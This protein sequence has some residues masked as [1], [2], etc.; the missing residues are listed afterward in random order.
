MKR[1]IIAVLAAA[2][3]AVTFG[4]G[5]SPAA[6][7]EPD[8]AAY[9][10]IGDSVASGNGLLPYYDPGCLRSDKAYP[11]VLAAALG[12]QVVSAACSGA[13]TSVVAAQAAGLAAT[14][15]LGGDTESGDD[16]RGR[17]RPAVDPGAG[18]AAAIWAS[19]RPLPGRAR[20]R[21]AG[22]RRWGPRA[23]SPRRSAS[24][25]PTRPSAL[26]VVTGYPELFG[27]FS[28]T[29][30]VGAAGP[31]TPM[32]F[33]QPQAG[34]LERR[35]RRPQLR[36][37][38]RHRAVPAGVR[39]SQR[40]PS[41][42]LRRVHRR[43]GG[44]RRSRAVRQRRALD[45]R[46]R[47]RQDDAGPR[48]PPERRRPAGVRGDH[49]GDDCS[50][51]PRVPPSGGGAASAHSVHN[52][53]QAGSRHPA[54]QTHGM[55]LT[56][57]EHVP[58]GA[59]ADAVYLGFVEWAAGPGSH[60][61]S[62]PGRGDHRD[63]VGV[64]RDPV[65]ADRHRQVPRRRRRACRVPRPRRANV[66]HRADQGAREREVL[67]PGRH[68]RRRQRRHGHG[69]LVGEPGCADHLLHRRD[70]GEHRPAKRSGCRS[71][72]GGDGRV[73]LL[74]RSRPRV[75]VAGA[76]PPAA[77][78]AVRADVGDTRRRHRHRR[79]PLS[80]H[81]SPDCPHHRC[82]APGAAALLLCAHSRARDRRGAA[83]DRPGA[84]LH[85]PLLAGGGHGARA[86]PVQHPHR[87]PGA[88]GCHRRGDRRVPLHDGV[89]PD[90]V[91]LR[92]RRNRRAPRRD[93]AALSPPRRD[94]RAAR[95]PARHLRHRHARRRHQRPDPHGDDH[96]A[97]EVR[98]TADAAAQRAR[99]PPGR[100]SRRPCRIRHGRNRRG[101][102]AR[103]RDRERGDGRQGRAT[104]R[105]S[106][107]RSS[108][109]R[110]RRDS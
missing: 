83:A 45:Q 29:C 85:R 69:R 82:R 11:S 37:P 35:G 5:V 21:R 81:R 100:G 60:A 64:E 26:I 95:S 43:D 75:G 33:E 7:D 10:A 56:L 63:R 39:G 110:R 103:S 28:G 102:G 8:G 88:A 2:A 108:A 20:R 73:P 9:V 40:R 77:A 38:R 74:R 93:A 97:R 44:I 19:P 55:P 78:R 4:A 70:P 12:G 80:S 34:M 96:R 66:L 106:C 67:R 87:Q 1:R 17:E 15:V 24:S 27:S 107:A 94:A 41:R 84:G 16:H 68:L 72:P 89:R 3:L 47:Q 14:G 101:D 86:G 65:D 32:K 99:V 98:R 79:R 49:R 42:L 25:G 23:A 54:W 57:A 46:T 30:S 104:T 105:R 36:G 59:D 31:G 50:A 58:V 61:L 91:A 6:A 90:A 18:S 109:R 71:R 13:S 51:R 92:A 48:V 22:P 62:R 52:L 53:C 76:A